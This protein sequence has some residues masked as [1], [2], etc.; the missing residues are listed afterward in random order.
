MKK[1][2][3]SILILVLVYMMSIMIVL[4]T[5]MSFYK[6][7]TFFN[8]VY[9]K[10]EEMMF[11]QNQNIYLL[12]NIN[13][14]NLTNFF[15]YKAGKYF[16]KNIFYSADR[17]K[18]LVNLN[19]NLSNNFHIN[20]KISGNVIIYSIISNYKNNLST[21]YLIKKRAE[22]FVLIEKCYINY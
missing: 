21:I 1:R 15:E 12:T 13:S 6:N 22:K 7:I 10:K 3:S 16:V 19:I 14:R 5:I 2:K 9:N 4:T 18:S 17:L 20:G 11:Y 8:R